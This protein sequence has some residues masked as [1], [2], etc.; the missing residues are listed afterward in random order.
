M[1][2]SKPCGCRVRG[3]M[4]KRVLLRHVHF[5]IYLVPEL[6]EAKAG[7]SSTSNRRRHI[8]HTMSRKSL[9]SKIHRL[10][11][12]STSIYDRVPL[13]RKRNEIRLLELLPS[14]PSK[15][16]ACKFHRFALW[17]LM[18]CPNYFA[19]SYT[20]GAGPAEKQ[21]VVDG[22]PFWVRK[23]LWQFLKQAQKKKTA[24]ELA[25]K[26]LWIDAICINQRSTFEKNHQVSMMRRIYE[27][28][29]FGS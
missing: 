3:C 18:K 22:K 29:S 10:R 26:Y 1:A 24:S 27:Q 4:F 17:P 7:K 16:I 11:G 6:G 25:V 5:N 28:V 23:N 19:L 2:N 9:A 21:I 12:P 15:L 13:R 20:W 14:S 8:V